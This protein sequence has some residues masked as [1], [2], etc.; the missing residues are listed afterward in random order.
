MVEA[1]RAATLIK[2]RPQLQIVLGNTP[3]TLAAKRIRRANRIVYPFNQ[4]KCD[5]HPSLGLTIEERSKTK[6]A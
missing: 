4:D 5:K 6:R 3:P 2:I 1:L